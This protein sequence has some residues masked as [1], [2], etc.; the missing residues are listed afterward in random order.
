MAL[1]L[2]SCKMMKFAKHA[3]PYLCLILSLLCPSLS[4]AGRLNT[5]ERYHSKITTFDW[6]P[7]PLDNKADK[8]IYTS[9]NGQP[10]KEEYDLNA[11]G[12]IDVLIE[13]IRIKNLKLVIEDKN[14][15]GTVDRLTYYFPNQVY[16]L[17]DGNYDRVLDEVMVRNL[18][19]KTLDK[20]IAINHRINQLRS[21]TRLIPQW[22]DLLLDVL[23]E[24][25]LT[26]EL[27]YAIGTLR[28]KYVEL[29]ALLEEALAS[30]DQRL[31]SALLDK[32]REYL[33]LP[34]DEMIPV[35]KITFDETMYA[36]AKHASGIFVVNRKKINHSL[37][38]WLGVVDHEMLHAIQDIRC[39]NDLK[40][41]KSFDKRI[42]YSSILYFI[43]HLNE[44][45]SYFPKTLSESKDF[46]RA[47]QEFL[48]LL[49][50]VEIQS[51][52]EAYIYNYE[53]RYYYSFEKTAHD[54]LRLARD[55]IGMTYIYKRILFDDKMEEVS[56][57]FRHT[58]E[59]ASRIYYETA[60]IA[61]LN[62]SP[63]I[64]KS[65]KKLKEQYQNT[66]KEK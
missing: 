43:H 15:D 49:Q 58:E 23:E 31:W 13:W 37:E 17:K 60:G 63:S 6:I 10:L 61:L 56:H 51:E 44:K 66:K 35:L 57:L 26:E 39:F 64:E 1:L 9:Y 36:F 21:M 46:T 24:R 27:N 18:F 52:L 28:E 50:R 7:K 4:F 19:D 53:R 3:I 25:K 11:D 14:Y 42:T 41:R 34:S 62:L 45:M 2:H 33:D 5:E 16:E 20:T 55:S 48:E 38:T 12:F 22:I 8:W 59:D 47:I 29:K 54:L 65:Y 32:S 40:T 30:E